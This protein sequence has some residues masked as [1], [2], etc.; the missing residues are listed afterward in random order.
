MRFS[1]TRFQ[2]A[3]TAAFLALPAG[4]QPQSAPVKLLP[5]MEL[6]ADIHRIEAEVAFTQQTRMRGLMGRRLM[7]PIHGMLFV[8]EAPAAKQCMWMRNTL[9]PLSV[10]FIDERGKILNIED[11]QP[12]TES[13]HCSAGP[14][15]FALEMNLG[16]FKQRGIG[17]G[18]P[19]GGIER[20]PAPR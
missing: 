2:V 10:A 14:A 11:M 12:Q 15:R 4:A 19:I 6:N 20:A 9:I 16:W 3:L 1:C 5:M 7:G 13:N 18:M 17:A 8:F